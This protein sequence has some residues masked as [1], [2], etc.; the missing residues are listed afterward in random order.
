MARR[1]RQHFANPSQKGHTK[2]C[3]RSFTDSVQDQSNLVIGDNL[4]L[5]PIT[6]AIDSQQDIVS[7]AIR[8]TGSVTRKAIAATDQSVMWIVAL[9]K[10]D[11]TTGNMLQVVNPY[12]VDSLASQ[13]IMG[14]GFLD[15]PGLYVNGA[16]SDSVSGR[17]V[18]FDIHVKAM[19]KLER[20]THTVSLTFASNGAGANDDQVF[21]RVVTSLLM[22]WQ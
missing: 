15:V 4:T 11:I 17:A 21:I 9:Q 8:I 18:A 7:K 12:D 20:N 14:F 19:R 13:D 6:T 22:K 2:W 3:R 1:R 10:F 5:C 16:G